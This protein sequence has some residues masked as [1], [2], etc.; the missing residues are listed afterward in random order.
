[1]GK[2]FTPRCARGNTDRD[3]WLVLVGNDAKAVYVRMSIP[4]ENAARRMLGIPMT[5]P[6][7]IGR[8]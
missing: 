8:P 4:D 7:V 2:K 3:E 5:T 6:V 1:M